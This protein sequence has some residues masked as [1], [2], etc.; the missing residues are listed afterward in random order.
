MRFIK[1]Y[2][3]PVYTFNVTY[4]FLCELVRANYNMFFIIKRITICIGKDTI[5]ILGF[6]NDR[7]EKKLFLQFHTPL[8]SQCCRSNDK[9]MTMSL[10]PLL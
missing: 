3:I 6:Q 1:D 7:R 8:F 5:K 4:L 10:C 9:Y 2:Q